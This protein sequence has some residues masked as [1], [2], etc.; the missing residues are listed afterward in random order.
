MKRLQLAR[1]VLDQQLI[2]R[3]ECN[4]GKV[5][6]IGLELRDGEPPRVAF[7][8]MGSDVLARRLSPRL[9]RWL[10]ALR[11]LIGRK[12]PEP[13]RVEWSKVVK[14][15]NAVTIDIDSD[16]DAPNHVEHWLA[17]HLI[18]RIPGASREKKKKEPEQHNQ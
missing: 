17:E 2:D 5:D 16:R 9:E 7:L 4:A 13:Y 14:I 8:D 18:G 15:A 10:Q 12:T 6:G 11:K 3:Y 1:D